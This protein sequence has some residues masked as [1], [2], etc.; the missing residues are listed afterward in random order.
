MCMIC[1]IQN[2]GPLAGRAHVLFRLQGLPD[3][4][5]LGDPLQAAGGAG[6]EG[7]AE[8]DRRKGG[9][10]FP[11]SQKVANVSHVLYI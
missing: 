6:E 11:G 5:V 10:S 2:P 8:A 7:Q 1:M 9:G 4:G 3:H